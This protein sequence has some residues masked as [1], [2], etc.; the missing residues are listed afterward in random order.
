MCLCVCMCLLCVLCFGP[1][2]NI[3]GWQGPGPRTS[4]V[5]PAQVAAPEEAAYV[6][7]Y[8]YIYII[9]RERCIYI[10]IYIYIYIG[11]PRRRQAPDKPEV[12]GSN[13]NN[14]TDDDLSDNS[15]RISNN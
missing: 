15:D 9:E 3:R 4:R 5:P 7:V 11:A 10:Y 14:D 1:G 8:I 2:L 6:C 12:H 13:T